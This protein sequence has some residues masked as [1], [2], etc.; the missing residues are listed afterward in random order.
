MSLQTEHEP[1]PWLQGLQ[2]VQS[3][4]DIQSLITAKVPEGER[5]EYKRGLSFP[6]GSS[7]TWESGRKLNTEA[8]KKILQEMVAFANAYGGT[9]LLGIAE[10]EAKPPWPSKYMPCRIVQI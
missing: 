7:D 4:Q 5:L 10:S 1:N 8:K 6:K 3:L 9:L 2:P